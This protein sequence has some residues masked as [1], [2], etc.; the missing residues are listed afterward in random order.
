M[1]ASFSRGGER[2]C[3]KKE[4]EVEGKD[5]WSLQEKIDREIKMR[6]KKLQLFLC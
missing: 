5:N 2:N 1:A 6:K 4:K 3:N